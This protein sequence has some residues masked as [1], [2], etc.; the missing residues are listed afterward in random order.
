[1]GREDARTDG[2]DPAEAGRIVEALRPLAVSIKDLNL[3][4]RNARAHPT[5]SIDAIKRSLTRFGQR[6]PIVVQRRENGNCIV[7]AGNARLTAASALGWDEIAAVFVEEDDSNAEAFAIADNRTAELSG[8]DTDQLETILGELQEEDFDIED[9][10]FSQ[11]ELET[12]FGTTG[13]A[14]EDMLP[15]K[16]ENP[17]TR[18]GDLWLLGRHRLLCGDSSSPEALDRLMD[19]EPVHLVNMDPPYNVAVSPRSNMAIA[20]GASSYPTA[21]DAKRGEARQLRARDRAIENDCMP[22]AQFQKV[23]E[24][25][26]GNASRLMVDGAPFYVWG[27]YANLSVYPPAMVATGLHFA[28]CII[29]V[30]QHPVMTRKDFMGDFEIAFYGWKLGGK[31]R[32][33]GG[34]SVSDVWTVKKVGTNDRVHLCLHPEA[35]VQTDHGFR[36]IGSVEVGTMVYAGDG[37]FRPV[38]AVTTHDYE[39]EHL[40]RIAAKGG[41]ATVDASD[42]HPFLIWRPEKKG[43]R[44][45]GG[46]AGWI[47]ADEIQV[48]DYTMTP[49]LAE[50]EEDPHPEYSESWWFIF[51]L[52]LADGH[53]QKAGHGDNIYPRFTLNKSRTDLVEKIEAEFESVS[54]YEPSDYGP[55]SHA[56]NVVA[57]DSKAGAEFARLGSRLADNKRLAPEVFQLPRAKRLAVFNGWVAGDGCQVEGRN[58]LQGNT[59]SADLAAHLC[60]LGESVGYRSSTYRYDPPDDLGGIGD[61]E[62]KSRRPVHNIYFYADKDNNRMTTI[63]H[64]GRTYLLRYVKSVEHIR[65]SGEVVNLSV[66]GTPS[67]QTRIGC[68][69]NTEKPV[70]LARRAIGYSSQAGDNVLD[71]FGGSGST[72]IG[73]EETDRR[74]FLMELDALY[75][76]V[77][78]R[79]FEQFTGTPARLGSDKGPTFSSVKK[80]RLKNPAE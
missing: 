59:V 39:S 69:H 78:V 58:Y 46:A 25:W 53:M 8:W 66:E 45:V 7:R 40:V 80:R 10:G 35:E 76:D 9:L 68:S 32:W 72:L 67:F 29:W 50:P 49:R 38:T 27:G 4:P 20:A 21:G 36:P 31:H 61:R 56:L 71:L 52:Y 28:Q 73:A 63:E 14:G 5:R 16:P 11:R 19:G 77:I 57:F 22:P 17:V 23:L 41:N 26:F 30:K 74:A 18:L 64:E 54:V 1:M 24:A 75:C 42:N 6:V 3:D 62:F 44:I 12:M 33:Y 37:S 60:L 34:N 55:P 15:E 13:D 79:R 65:Y 2:Q 47:R 43:H 70:E 51:G 48:G